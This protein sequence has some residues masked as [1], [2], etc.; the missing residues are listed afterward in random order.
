MRG[1][2]TVNEEFE[3]GFNQRFESRWYRAE[4]AGRFVM[5]GFVVLAFLGLLGR[6]PYSHAHKEASS[7]RLAVD[8]EPV[9]RH[10]TST[11]IT[12]HLKEAIEG[13]PVRLLVD[14]HMIEPLGFQRA[15]PIPDHTSISDEGAWLTFD[16]LDG[17]NTL[18]RLNLTPN[19][20]GLVPMEITDGT[21]TVSWTMFVV[22]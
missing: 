5:A 16:R 21:D 1:A 22:P 6:G 2:D 18:V 17:R 19:A 15:T 8:Y 10:S 12:V 9:A 7:G 20:L 4:I 14:Q 3:V 13:R 11:V